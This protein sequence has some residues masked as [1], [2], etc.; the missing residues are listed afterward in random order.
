MQENEHKKY[1]FRWKLFVDADNGMG[2]I[3]NFF[4]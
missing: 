4:Y 1:T 3:Y 2:I